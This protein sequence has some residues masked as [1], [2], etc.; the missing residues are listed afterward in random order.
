MVGSNPSALPWTSLQAFEVASRLGTFK[1]AAR[2]LAVTPTAIS[3]Q[4]R[5]LEAQLGFA[6]FERL[7][8]SVQLTASGEVLADEVQETFSRLHHTLARLRAE[9]SAVGSETLTVSVVPSFAAKWLAPRLHEFQS[10]HPRIGL[11]V[12]AD[13][14]LVDLRR[15]RHIDVAVRYSP[16]IQDKALA[17]HRLWASGEIV[18]VCAP[19]LLRAS[20]IR[21]AAD[22]TR[23]M[24]IR[25]APKSQ[26]RRSQA[27]PQG[28][29]WLAWLKAAGVTVDGGIEK[30]VLAGPIFNTSQLAIEA[31]LSG[32]G[33]AL[34]PKIL[35][36]RDLAGRRLKQLSVSIA[37]PNKFWVLCRADRSRESR[38][39]T[40]IGWLRDEAAKSTRRGD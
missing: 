5:R 6:L 14:A 24:L 12:V 28:T 16:G 23:H 36:E 39:R 34:A 30:K 19:A 17:A 29:D 35:V 31:A 10:L 21:R 18:A 3:H 40:F 15:S 22:V 37:D 11:R 32:K 27:Q 33:I 20:S 8:R 25:T 26:P 9:G 1:E 13:E 38:I 7:H 4:I 2:E